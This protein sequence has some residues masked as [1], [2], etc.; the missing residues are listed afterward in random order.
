MKGRQEASELTIVRRRKSRGGHMIASFKPVTS[1]VLASFCT[2]HVSRGHP[3]S[4]P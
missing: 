3:D 1:V 2:R 4:L